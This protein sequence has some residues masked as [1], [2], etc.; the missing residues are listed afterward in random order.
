VT[1]AVARRL[2]GGAVGFCLL[3]ALGALVS[4]CGDRRVSSARAQV[5]FT[6]PPSWAVYGAAAL[7]RTPKWTALLTNSP[8]FLV[9]ATA[10]PDPAPTDPF[11]PSP[12]PWAIAMVSSLTS[13]QQQQI[14]LESLSDVLVDIDGLSQEGVASEELGQPELLVNGSMHGTVVTYEVGSGDQAIDFKQAAWLN[15]A[16]TRVWVLMAGCS[17]TCYQIEG[18]VINRIIGSFYV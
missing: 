4:G 10:S 7:E 2:A 14:S 8:Q 13:A 11:S 5:Y 3:V 15:S 6:V 1:P 17:P 9:A 12:Y 16:S 18:A